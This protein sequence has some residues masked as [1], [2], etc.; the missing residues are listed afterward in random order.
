MG[1]HKHKLKHL[2]QEERLAIK[3]LTDSMPVYYGLKLKDDYKMIGHS[4]SEM[5]D[6]TRLGKR[7]IEGLEP[8]Y[9]IGIARRRVNLNGEVEEAGPG[10]IFR[11]K[12]LKKITPQGVLMDAYKKGGIKAV[13]EAHMNYMSRYLEYVQYCS[14]HYGTNEKG[15]PQEEPQS[16]IHD[17]T[18]EPNT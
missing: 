2:T 16:E 5:E 3:Q 15:A 11:R 8:D 18:N 13:P 9:E 17:V 12:L 14:M 4:K 6:M 7:P 10:M 1:L